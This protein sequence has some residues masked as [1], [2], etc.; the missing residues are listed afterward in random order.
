MKLNTDDTCVS[1]NK[2]ILQLSSET[3]SLDIPTNAK[4]VVHLRNI[5]RTQILFHVTVKN[6][7]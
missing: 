5:C 6:A 4:D 2:D 1:S 3:P 7:A